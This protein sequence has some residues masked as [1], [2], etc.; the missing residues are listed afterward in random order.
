MLCCGKPSSQE[1][2]LAAF[3]KR[4]TPA[5]SVLVFFSMNALYE[6]VIQ[7][8]KRCALMRSLVS[9]RIRAHVEEVNDSVA[10]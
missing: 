6:K 8:E 5:W 3:F 7:V 9:L 1:E 10:D 4:A 2:T